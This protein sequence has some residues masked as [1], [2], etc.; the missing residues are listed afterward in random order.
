VG[1]W[2]GSTSGAAYVLAGGLDR[3]LLAGKKPS[4]VDSGDA[5]LIGVRFPVDPARHLTSVTF[6]RGDGEDGD[7]MLTLFHAMLLPPQP[8]TVLTD[9]AGHGTVSRSDP[10]VPCGAGCSSHPESARVKLTANPDADSFFV[11]FTAGCASV[12][13]ATCTVDVDAAKTITAYFGGGPAAREPAGGGLAGDTPPPASGPIG[14]D[15]PALLPAAPVLKTVRLGALVSLSTRGRCA[16]RPRLAL[17]LKPRDTRV[18]EVTA[19]VRPRSRKI[20]GAAL[21]RA[22]VLRRIPRRAFTLRLVVRTGK[23][24]YA[25]KRRFRGCGPLRRRAA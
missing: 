25:A 13:G 22:V 16:R 14:G 1:D 2:L 23:A 7:E 8:L 20:T 6:V 24:T 12:D 3:M 19:A 18:L 21:A 10:G 17:R 5:A 4:C 15:G 9:G 11:G